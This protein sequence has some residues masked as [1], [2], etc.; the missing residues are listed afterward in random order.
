MIESEYNSTY[1]KEGKLWDTRKKQYSFNYYTMKDG[2]LLG[3]FQGSR[4]DRPDLDFIIKFLEIGEKSRLRTPKHLH[5]VVDLIIKH[6]Y[7]PNEVKNFAIKYFDWYKN[8]QPFE[9]LSERNNYNPFTPSIIED[10]FKEL[11]I[12]GTYSLEYLA[13][14]IELFIK[15]EKR[16]EGAFMFKN[17]LKIMIDYCDGKKDYFQVLNHASQV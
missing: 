10:S 2:L 7:H 11:N 9:S 14:L 16:S 3:L 15:C 4:G 12:I 13:H 6:Q 17:L 5:W 1:F 8:I